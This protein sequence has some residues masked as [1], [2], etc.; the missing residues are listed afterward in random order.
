MDY[1]CKE[2]IQ[3]KIYYE[4]FDFSNIKLF[5]DKYLGGVFPID[6]V[7][8]KAAISV[9]NE[10]LIYSDVVDYDRGA[11]L[12]VDYNYL[13]PNINRGIVVYIGEKDRYGKVVIIEGED[14]IDIWYGNLCN[15]IVSLYDVVSSGDYL[16]ESCDNKLYVVYTKKNEFLDY[17]DYLD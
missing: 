12:Q 14:G 16:G 13:V 7:S 3:R 17:K 15:I 2:Y 4:Y 10:G 9:F 5:Y 1:N 8:N 6:G 11:M